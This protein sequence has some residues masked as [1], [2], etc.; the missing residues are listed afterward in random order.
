MKRRA[1]RIRHTIMN[2]KQALMAEL[3][4]EVAET[5]AMT[6]RKALNPRLLAALGTVRREAFVPPDESALAYV[7]APLPIGGGQTISQPFI[8]AIMTELLDLDPNDVVLEIGTGS[9]YQ[10]AILA[11]LVRQVYTVEVIPELANSARQ[12]LAAEG[13]RNVEVRCSDGALGWPEHAP[14]DAIVVT[15]AAPEIP[16]ELVKQLAPGGRMIIPVGAR[17]DNQLLVLIEKDIAGRVEHRDIMDVAFVPL[18]TETRR[19]R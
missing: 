15:A 8:V 11:E 14:Y 12:A 2:E 5:A 17:F 9:G 10:A 16:P 19:A 13:C 1:D 4:A 6:G 3:R 18:V 7:N